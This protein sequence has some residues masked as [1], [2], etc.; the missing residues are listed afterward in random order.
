MSQADINILY[1][2]DTVFTY[3][4]ML[5]NTQRRNKTAPYVR[6]IFYLLII[7]HAG[8]LSARRFCTQNCVSPDWRNPIATFESIKILSQR[9]WPMREK[10]LINFCATFRLEDS[11]LGSHMACFSQPLANDSVSVCSVLEILSLRLYVCL[12]TWPLFSLF[13]SSNSRKNLQNIDLDKTN[14]NENTSKSF[15]NQIF[16]IN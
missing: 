16:T 9:L 14:S 5:N 10:R 7:G 3:A 12:P 2:R 1:L 4:R 13:D 8:S 11:R 15:V 6:P